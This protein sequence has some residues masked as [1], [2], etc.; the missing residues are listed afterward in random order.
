[1]S[2]QSI[3]K[4]QF[5]YILDKGGQIVFYADAE[6]LQNPQDDALLTA[7]YLTAL[8]QFTKAITNEEMMNFFEMGKLKVFVKHSSL[9]PVFYVYLVGKKLKISEKKVNDRLNKLAKEFESRFSIYDLQEWDG[10]TDFF[11]A[12]IKPFKKIFRRI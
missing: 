6:N 7:S 1:M 11:S 10:S 2:Q 12:F 4:Q 9:I 8:L 3:E 5:V